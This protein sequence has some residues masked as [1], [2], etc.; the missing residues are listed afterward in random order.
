MK[1][2]KSIVT[3]VFYRNGI[4][5]K[6]S[7]DIDSTKKAI[8][9]G[10]GPINYS[11][12]EKVV[13]HELEGRKNP[14]IIISFDDPILEDERKK[15]EEECINIES[16][17]IPKI[18]TVIKKSGIMYCENVRAYTLIYSKGSKQPATYTKN[19]G[20]VEKLLLRN[21]YF[22][23]DT[24]ITV[25]KAFVHPDSVFGLSKVIMINGKVLKIARRRIVSFWEWM[26]L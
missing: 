12:I 7:A 24:G 4:L 20:E 9:E 1:T 16:R 22:R 18:I 10:G 3:I 17:T 6:N 25:C 15:Q 13:A 26:M 11:E 14:K 19:L 21:S 5:Q 23:I 8:E 2:P